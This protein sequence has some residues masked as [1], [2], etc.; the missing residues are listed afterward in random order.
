MISR[1]PCA[2]L[3]TSNPLKKDQQI[4]L[5]MISCVKNH[6]CQNKKI[7]KIFTYLNPF[8]GLNI[9][10]MKAGLNLQAK[11]NHNGVAKP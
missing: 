7:L 3:L 5:K 8:K 2:L 10:K 9:H 6:P 4:R 11:K 1:K